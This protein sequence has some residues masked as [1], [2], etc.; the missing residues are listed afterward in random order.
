MRDESEFLDSPAEGKSGPSISSSDSVPESWSS[1]ACATEKNKELIKTN[2]VAAQ[3][4]FHKADI[5]ML[6]YSTPAIA[7]FSI[8]AR[9]I[10]EFSSRNAPNDPRGR[11]G[12][13][14][15]LTRAGCGKNRAPNV[16]SFVL[17]FRRRS[18]FSHGW[19]SARLKKLQ[20]EPLRVWYEPFPHN[21][22][23]LWNESA[24]YAWGIW[25]YFPSGVF[26]PC[27]TPLWCLRVRSYPLKITVANPP[28]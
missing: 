22:P 4:I 11:L 14:K 9:W 10:R 20:I 6:I 18:H 15:C 23:R 21:Y 27:W 7:I 16:R 26:V 1:S 19:P 13:L 8:S 12:G 24:A 25:A 3:R 2:I 5:K 17:G 28:Q